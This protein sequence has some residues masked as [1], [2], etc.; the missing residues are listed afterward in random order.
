VG[1]RPTGAPRPR[2]RPRV[3]ARRARIAA[4]FESVLE[5][6]P[7]A[8]PLEHAMG[9]VDGSYPTNEMGEEILNGIESGS[10]DL[11]ANLTSSVP[12]AVR[13]I[14]RDSWDYAGKWRGRVEQRLAGEPAAPGQPIDALGGAAAAPDLKGGGTG[15]R[16]PGGEKMGGMAL[17]AGGG[18]MAGSDD[19]DQSKLGK[20]GGGIG[21]FAMA[22]TTPGGKRLGK[23]LFDAAQKGIPLK[24]MMPSPSAAGALDSQHI[25]AT[26]PEV[27]PTSRPFIRKSPGW[28]RATAGV[29]RR[30]AGTPQAARAAGR[31]GAR[32]T[33]SVNRRLCAL[34][35]T[36][37]LHAGCRGPGATRSRC[38]RPAAA[39]RGRCAQACRKASTAPP[40]RRASRAPGGG[41]AQ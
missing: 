11:P 12:E 38:A 17:A 7:N 25:V 20:L 16:G 27:A 8:A 15:I 40:P 30:G 39:P 32:A 2:Q 14:Q 26:P 41:R 10:T 23:G 24:G 28:L 6:D 4:A 22:S 3:F 33:R 35:A 19:E 18:A 21:M 1:R 13:N 37:S 34:R 29:G 9:A 31:A 36:R 5:T